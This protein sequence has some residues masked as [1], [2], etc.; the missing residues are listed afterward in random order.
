M[1]APTIQKQE[2]K[3]TDEKL[4]P[5]DQTNSTDPSN[6]TINNDSANA[7]TTTPS[8]TSEKPKSTDTPATSVTPA[9]NETPQQIYAREYTNLHQAYYNLTQTPVRTESDGYI[10]YTVTLSVSA[11]NNVSF[12]TPTLFAQLIPST[13]NRY[14]CSNPSGTMTT[15]QYGAGNNSV[16]ISCRVRACPECYYP[17][18][19][20]HSYGAFSVEV[21][22]ITSNSTPTGT[23]SQTYDLAPEY[24]KPS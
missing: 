21:G 8:S 18:G 5:T 16:S 7:T 24:D 1:S 4:T 14:S 13:P 19:P 20:L 3:K 6:A 2:R 22:G 15:F 9:K 23:G 17:G 10:N 12:G 11:F